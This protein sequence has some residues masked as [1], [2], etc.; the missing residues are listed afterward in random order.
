MDD[1]K[2][3]L[4]TAER[5]VNLEPSE[6]S[7]PSEAL[8]TYRPRATVEHLVHS[9]KRVAGLKP[10]RVWKEDSIGDAIL[11][12]LL[13]E[14]TI[15]MAGYEM[16]TEVRNDRGYGRECRHPT[17]FMVWSLDHSTVTR[18]IEKGKARKAHP[19]IGV[20]HPKRSSPTSL[21]I[22]EGEE[23]FSPDFSRHFMLRRWI[24]KT[25]R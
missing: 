1:W 23:W 21:R 11:S 15:A 22:S 3:S 17:G 18:S 8:N 5:D 24:S 13:A 7:T 14:T 16:E 4:H 20:R 9:L 12:A 25:V 2:R 6:Q 19:S 10:L